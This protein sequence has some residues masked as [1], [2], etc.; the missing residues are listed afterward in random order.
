MQV[1]PQVMNRL[2]KRASKEGWVKPVGGSF[3]KAF[4]KDGDVWGFKY[5]GPEGREV[6]IYDA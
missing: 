4:F 6:T 2:I 1:E 5:Y 3:A